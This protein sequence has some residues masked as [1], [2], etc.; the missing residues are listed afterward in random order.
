MW[1]IGND[2]DDK[3]LHHVIFESHTAFIH[4]HT[5]KKSRMEGSKYLERH[6]AITVWRTALTCNHSWTR[7][8]RYHSF[9]CPLVLHKERYLAQSGFNKTCLLHSKS[10]VVYCCNH[11]AFVSGAYTSDMCGTKLDRRS[12]RGKVAVTAACS[13]CSATVFSNRIREMTHPKPLPLSACLG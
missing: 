7:Q 6:H 13:C 11:V 5:M 2:N 12:S 3:M 10:L 9:T 1:R 4:C 8:N